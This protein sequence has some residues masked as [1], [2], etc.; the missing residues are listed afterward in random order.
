[1]MEEACF[2]GLRTGAGFWVIWFLA[3]GYLVL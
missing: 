3:E 2:G 1:M